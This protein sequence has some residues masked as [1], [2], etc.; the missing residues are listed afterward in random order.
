MRRL[1]PKIESV[2]G[3]ALQT[4]AGYAVWTEWTAFS[5]L[6]VGAIWLVG[7][8]LFADGLRRERVLEDDGIHLDEETTDDRPDVALAFWMFLAL[9]LFVPVYG[10]IG[11]L[12]MEWLRRRRGE[13]KTGL[14]D[15]YV[16]YIG[17]ESET[18]ETDTGVGLG[19]VE[20]MVFEELS[21]QSYTDI[22]RGPNRNLKKALI[23]KILQEWTP[24]AIPLLQIALRDEVYEIR[25]YASTALTTIE[26]RMNRRI[27]EIKRELA[28]DPEEVSAR[29]RLARSYL[30]YAESGLLDDSS[31]H[32]YATLAVEAVAN[33]DSET[34][35]D[36]VGKLTIEMRAYRLQGRTD[37]E[38]DACGRILDLR[39]DHQEALGRLCDIQFERR[40]FESLQ[41]TSR[42]FLAVTP[43]DHP[44]IESARLWAGTP[45]EEVDA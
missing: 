7:G 1:L 12:I 4:L 45:G 19:S 30:N 43:E 8:L 21:I 36:R 38:F 29:Y 35:E 10:P 14:I 31:K 23:S 17:S 9:A 15:E 28:E 22:V 39:A 37:D 16:D 27:Q 13:D 20:E 26:D 5:V 2:A 34:E 40:D 3:L 11:G 6:Q 44:A 41:S 25:S 24:G 33:T 32:H 18:P 42:R